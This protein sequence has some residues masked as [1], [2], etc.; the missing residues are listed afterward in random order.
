MAF[1]RKTNSNLCLPPR[2]SKT[3]FYFLMQSFYIVTNSLFVVM[4][5]LQ[6]Y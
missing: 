1:T 2:M 6:Y 4:R 3:S 5:K